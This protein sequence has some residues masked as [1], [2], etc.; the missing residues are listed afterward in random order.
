MDYTASQTNAAPEDHLMCR[1]RGFGARRQYGIRPDRE[2]IILA[3]L[4]ASVSDWWLGGADIA[5]T[6]LR[7]ALGDWLE[8]LSYHV[9][10][11]AGALVRC[12]WQGI[13]QPH[14]PCSLAA[15][16]Y[17]HYYDGKA[18][19]LG[20]VLFSPESRRWEAATQHLARRVGAYIIPHT[21]DGLTGYMT[22]YPDLILAGRR[23]CLCQF[24]AD[25]VCI[26]TSDSDP[27]RLSC[28]IV[29]IAT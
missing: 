19:G 6:A 28:S 4:P 29:S 16:L 25:S 13:L 14:C 8:M 17:V 20:P 10:R 9:E 3:E 2:Y 11:A 15:E 22:R 1:S 21:P 7:Q 18:P 27:L 24:S 12:E 23:P 5:E 26:Q